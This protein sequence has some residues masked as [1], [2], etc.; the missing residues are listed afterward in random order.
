MLKQIEEKNHGAE[1]VSPE[2]LKNLES[3]ETL[4]TTLVTNATEYSHSQLQSFRDTRS[5]RAN[6]VQILRRSSAEIPRARL[7]IILKQHAS[8]GTKGRPRLWSE[9]SFLQNEE[10]EALGEVEPILDFWVGRGEILWFK[11]DKRGSLEDHVIT[12]PMAFIRSLRSVI[13]HKAI[14]NLG[15]AQFLGEKNDLLYKG[16]LSFHSFK[17]LHGSASDQK[18]TDEEVWKYLEELGLICPL[19]KNG[20]RYAL[21]PSLISDKMEGRVNNMEKAMEKSPDS[22]C[23]EYIFDRNSSSIG[24][25]HKFLSSFAEAFLWA[26]NGGEILLSSSQKVEKRTLGTIGGVYGVLKWHTEGVR[27]P[28]EFEFLIL[29]RETTKNS[30]DVEPDD[31]SNSFAV[32]RGIQFYIKPSEGLM[33]K[34]TFDIMK[35]IDSVFTVDLTSA[36]KSLVCKKCP[37]ETGTP[38]YFVLKE[39][40]EL[41]SEAT[42]C[43]EMIHKMDKRIICLLKDS[44]KRKPFKLQSL[45]EMEKSELGLQEFK[46]SE[47]R[48]KILRNGL[49]IGEQI[50][51][52]HD[53]ET[54]PANPIAQ[55]NPYAHVMVYVGPREKKGEVIHEVVHVGK[56]SMRGCSKATIKRENV[57]TAIKPH[58]HVF[59]G[60][61]IDRVQ[62]SGNIRQ[63]IAERAIACASAPKIVFNYDHRLRHRFYMTLIIER[64]NCETFCNMV[65][66]NIP[67]AVQADNTRTI[68]RGEIL[69][70]S[71]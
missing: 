48:A 52:Y 4:L 49:D 30:L 18:F 40:L 42:L 53:K 39:G 13:S 35:R 34:A 60:H 29:E 20:E 8:Q 14:N 36:T 65:V 24:V 67:Y 38:G 44:E 1:N 21:V 11:R 5:R 32:H 2:E 62:F 16:L 68:M 25:Y 28:E 69:S 10:E 9:D 33:T 6:P 66:F 45:M 56:D 41:V 59:L 47:I 37:L 57:F 15:G 58:N 26:E 17:H 64:N 31:P 70:K 61:K 55:V 50:W 7:S 22:I 71:R 63:R 54:D 46:T 3:L 51:V 19:K 23:I 27:E 43:S 12:N